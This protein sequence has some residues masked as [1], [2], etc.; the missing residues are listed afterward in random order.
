ML[1]PETCKDWSI[2]RAFHW[3]KKSY[4]TCSFGMHVYFILYI[5]FTPVFLEASQLVWKSSDPWDP[6]ANKPIEEVKQLLEAANPRAFLRM[7]VGSWWSCLNS[8]VESSIIWRFRTHVS[9]CLFSA[10]YPAG[11]QQIWPPL[12]NDS[13]FHLIFLFHSWWFR[14][15]ANQLSI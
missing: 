9:F 5:A 11:K 8:G 15:P 14:N 12:W 3:L 7:P 1:P 13:L 2:F 10:M 4:S 6:M